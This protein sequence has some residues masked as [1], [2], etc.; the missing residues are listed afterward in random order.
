[1][2]ETPSPQARATNFSS[3]PGA[4]PTRPGLEQAQEKASQLS[5][6]AQQTA[7]Q[8]AH[9]A[10]LQATSQAEFQKTRAV[11]TLVTVGQALRQTGQHLRDEQ[12]DTLGR[13]IE[14]AAERVEDA[15]DYL[16]TRDVQTLVGETRRFARQQPG[17]FLT[18]ALT[19][20]FL[21]A[22]FFMSS[23]RREPDRRALPPAPAP[24]TLGS[25]GGMEPRPLE[26]RSAG[27]WSAPR[28]A[29][30]NGTGTVSHSGLSSA[31]E[32]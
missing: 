31:T 16:R 14:Q 20:G 24:S 1:M 30:G 21:S 18:G 15:T 5:D 22:R 32:A 10:K 29:V 27:A 28:G 19:L 17:L 3:S 13:Y 4:E 6:Q 26:P 25:R 11:D 2:T 8:V 7:G 23:G 12:Q 9:Q